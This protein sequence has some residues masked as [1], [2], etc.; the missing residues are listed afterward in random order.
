M[1]VAG[2]TVNTGNKPR[3][4]GFGNNRLDL[5]LG[6]VNQGT[7][8]RFGYAFQVQFDLQGIS[9]LDVKLTRRVSHKNDYKQNKMRTGQQVIDA[10][11]AKP[12]LLSDPSETE[13]S[14]NPGNI[15]REEHRVVVQDGPGPSFGINDPGMYPLR[16]EGRF[17]LMLKDANNALL[18]S[19]EYYVRLLKRQ[20]NG[21]VEGEFVKLDE[22]ILG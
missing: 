15:Y 20:Y 7:G 1:K 3:Q 11:E 21:Q 13:D 9:G 4:T 10:Y 18:A 19:V 16:F 14:P 17:I 8:L 5:T 22:K 12:M 2:I 6:L